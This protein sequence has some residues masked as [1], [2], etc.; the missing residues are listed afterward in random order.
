MSV[1]FW[2]SFVNLIPGT[3]ITFDVTPSAGSDIIEVTVNAAAV[4]GG[5]SIDT[6]GNVV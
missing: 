3:G 2:R 1:Y 6:A 5:V 4:A